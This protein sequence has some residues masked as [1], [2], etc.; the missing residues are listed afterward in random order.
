MNFR[1]MFLASVIVLC[2][3]PLA[4][5][6]TFEI[7][8]KPPAVVVKN[9]AGKIAVSIPIDANPAQQK[10]QFSNF[11]KT[12]YVLNA[13]DKSKTRYI[14]AVNVTTNR[15][16][17][18]I[19]VGA[20]RQVQLLMSS[21]GR[22]LFCYTA[23]RFE[24]DLGSSA[25]KRAPQTLAAHKLAGY[26]LLSGLKPPFEPVIS[27]IDTASNEVV[28][29]DEWLKSF[30]A[31]VPKGQL[32]SSQ[33]LATSDGG[34]LIVLSKAFGRFW[35]VE[36]KPIGQQIAIFSGL[37]PHPTLVINPGGNVVEAML[38]Q[39]ERSL[40]VTVVKEKQRQ[41]SL[42]IID[43]ETG[44]TVNRAMTD[45]PAKLVQLGSKQGMWVMSGQEMR[46]I[47]ET[48]ELGDKPIL[49]NKPRKSD[50]G[51]QTSTSAFL[52]G[53]LGETIDLGE[54][55]AAILIN[56]QD[57]SSL[58]RVALLDLKEL[59][60]ESI[61]P[62]ITAAEEAN[63]LAHRSMITMLVNAAFLGTALA[64]GPASAGAQIPQYSPNLSFRNEL[65]AARPDG[66]FLYI[67]D[68]DS[69]EVTVIDVQAGTVL[70][71]IPVDHSISLIQVSPDGKHLLCLGKKASAIDLD[72]NNLEN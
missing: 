53:N 67:L 30:R 47:S 28:G 69:H 66:K 46:P 36:R 26:N 24:N 70:S 42:D 57:G 63:I 34:H 22:R 3:G 15:V 4:F 2:S 8:G 11:T 12:L 39:S 33:F 5:P 59:Q 18:V 27:V 13:A 23:S 25:G 40:F 55:H 20:G 50:P 45:Q 1:N 62:T 64:A 49:L 38:S 54:D 16:D 44:G 71:R 41:Q 29:T 10:F 48:G 35:D 60:V 43:I 72:S 6:Q 9:A 37:S 56:K 58:H 52:L 68:I 19:K 61:L 14:S 32:F 65:L 51:D 31:A 21:D 17:R 7:E